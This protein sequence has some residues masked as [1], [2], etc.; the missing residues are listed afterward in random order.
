MTGVM[1]IDRGH[2]ASFPLHAQ[3]PFNEMC[4][5]LD[6]TSFQLKQIVVER[7]IIT[8]ETA[9]KSQQPD[10]LEVIG[11]LRYFSVTEHIPMQYQTSAQAKRMI[12]DE[13]LKEVGW[14]TKGLEHGNDAAR[15]MLFYYLKQGWAAA[16]YDGKLFLLAE[17]EVLV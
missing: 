17:G 9:K 8:P 7:Y 14:Y 13:R 5:F 6:N 16:T 3:L 1:L 2:S 11:M 10:A 15:H 12:T 4:S